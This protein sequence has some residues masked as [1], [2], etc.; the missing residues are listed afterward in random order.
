MK[1]AYDVLKHLKKKVG[2]H[3][4]DEEY[5]LVMNEIRDALGMPRVVPKDKRAL[6]K[7]K[8]SELRQ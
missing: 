6:A 1:R 4:F 2:D 5:I 7:K 8:A 3:A